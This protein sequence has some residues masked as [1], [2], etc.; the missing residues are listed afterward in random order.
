MAEE[1]IA[2]DRNG[3]CFEPRPEPENGDNVI[4]AS[5]GLGGVNNINDVRV[6]QSALNDVGASNGGPFI[7]LKVDGISGPLTAKA[8]AN[9]QLRN[10]GFSDSRVDPK[11][12]T[13]RA[14]NAQR[15]NSVSAVSAV[16]A[17]PASPQG[18]RKTSTLPNPLIV[19]LIESLLPQI[20]AAIRAASFQLSL[21][22]PFVG[23]QKLQV[24]QG[25]FLAPA[26]AS[27]RLLN[28]IFSLDKFAN[29]QPA[30]ERLSV[31]FRNMDVA[32]NRRFETSPLA[33]KTLFVPNT[34]EFMER[35][36]AAYTTPGGAFALPNERNSLG[37]PN[38]LIFLCSNLATE[39]RD[40][41][42]RVAIHELAHYVSPKNDKTK[43]PAKGRFFANRQPMDALQP[44]QKIRNA[45][46]YAAYAFICAFRLIAQ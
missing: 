3:A 37:L 25:P 28:N 30:H 40:N 39:N 46:H 45:E 31:A 17:G 10:L 43:D 36:A 15:G 18:D 32:L 26:R 6:I 9:F 12:R 23:T 27:L 2:R 34:K 4:S 1:C 8:I 19:P 20:R 16:G 29:P 42:I 11:G 22:K 5:V 38:D 21:A 41:Q 7:P 33:S 35:Q 14:L 13:L 24:P 44:Q